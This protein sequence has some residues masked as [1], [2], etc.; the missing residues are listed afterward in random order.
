MGY[1]WRRMYY[2][3][4][5]PG[6]LRFG[7]SPGWVGRS[8]TGLP[9]TA[10]FLMRSGQLPQF[11][12]YLAQNPQMNSSQFAPISKE[13][14]A[15]ML[16]EQAKIIENELKSIKG[17]LENLRKNQETQGNPDSYVPIMQAQFPQNPKDELRFLED[18]KKQVEEE[19][20]RIDDRISELKKFM[21][22]EKR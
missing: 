5:M 7:Y 4:G 6:W 10:E 17:R 19:I 20:R 1:R 14:E 12:Q 16:E 2:L 11:R 13:E 21:N 22:K 15:K 18:Y 9:P 3:T 8:A